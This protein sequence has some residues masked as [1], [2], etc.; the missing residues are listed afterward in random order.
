MPFLN[1]CLVG[2]FGSPRIDYR[3]KAGT[4]IL[5]SLLEDLAGFASH[6]FPFWNLQK[7]ATSKWINF[8][9]GDVQGLNNG[10]S[11][12]EKDEPHP[13][14]PASLRHVPF[15]NMADRVSR[16][17]RSGDSTTVE[18]CGAALAVDTSVEGQTAPSQSH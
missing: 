12:K 2:R 5:T 6:V 17:L 16:L 9:L 15:V 8:S 3:T 14:V 7:E 10:L 13:V 11:S 18:T 4:R 1:L